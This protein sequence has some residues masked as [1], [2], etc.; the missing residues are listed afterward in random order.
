MASINIYMLLIPTSV[1]LKQISLLCPR[2]YIHWN[3]NLDVAK[4]PQTQ[5]VQK[6]ISDLQ[7]KT[8]SSSSVA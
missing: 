6:K 5:Q 3:I 4:S 7:P 2:P 1:F 8:W